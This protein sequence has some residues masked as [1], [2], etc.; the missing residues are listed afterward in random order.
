M[1]KHKSSLVDLISGSADGEIIFWNL[2][3]HSSKF[4]VNAHEQMVRGLSF[5][6]NHK[7]DEDLLFCSSGGDQ[8]IQLWSRNHIEKQRNKLDLVTSAKFKN[9]LPKATFASKHTLGYIDHSYGENQF[10][11]CGSVVQI[12]S[13]ERSQPIHVF[14]NWGVDTIS[15]LKYNPSDHHLILSASHDRNVVLYDI[16][17]KTPLERF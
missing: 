8:K 5:A 1:A 13:Y 11:S 2:A 10:A 15:R 7:L 14:N 4:I 6:N 9:F 17:G 16:R 12:W 3:D